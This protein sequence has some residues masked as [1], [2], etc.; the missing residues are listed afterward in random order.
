MNL[1][2]YLTSGEEMNVSVTENIEMQ[3]VESIAEIEQTKSLEFTDGS[4]SNFLPELWENL[5]QIGT[6]NISKLEII[7]NEKTYEYTNFSN[8]SYQIRYTNS[9]VDG[10]ISFSF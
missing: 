10:R 7:S 6:K 4:E 3:F 5:K 9:G 2:F 8:A 1:K